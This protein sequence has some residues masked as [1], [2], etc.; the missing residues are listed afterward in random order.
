MSAMLAGGQI[1]LRKDDSLGSS[2][3]SCD[4]GF[5]YDS[6]EMA[7]KCSNGAYLNIRGSGIYIQSG[8]S[9]NVAG[10]QV[11]GARQTGMGATLSA[12]TIGATYNST[13]QGQIQALYNKVILLETK[14]KAHGLIAD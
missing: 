9:Y 7:I 2:S 14:L 6:Q 4:I 11:L 1:L 8:Y 13:V 12:D 10:N 5:V 3:A